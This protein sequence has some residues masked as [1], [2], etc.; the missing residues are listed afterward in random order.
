MGANVQNTPEDA[1]RV[2]TWGFQEAVAVLTEEGIDM[3][4]VRAASLKLAA[5]LVKFG[6]LRDHAPTS[7][8]KLRVIRAPESQLKLPLKPRTAVPTENFNPPRPI[9]PDPDLVA[10]QVMLAAGF[11]EW[12]VQEIA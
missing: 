7:T 8:P 3:S 1:Q 9:D 2:L 4:V 11:H 6:T 5:F 12:A 10:T